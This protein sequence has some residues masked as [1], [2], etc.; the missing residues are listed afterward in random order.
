MKP[1]FEKEAQ[2]NSEMAYSIYDEIRQTCGFLR[3]VCI[4]RTMTELRKKHH[5]EVLDTP[6]KS[7]DYYLKRMTSMSTLLKHLFL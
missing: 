1:R 6:E 3:Y 2:H 7:H 4:L 5:Q